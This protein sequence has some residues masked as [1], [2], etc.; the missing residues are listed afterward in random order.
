M[1]NVRKTYAT[2]SRARFGYDEVDPKSTRR[3]RT[4]VAVIKVN[5][6]VWQTAMD[7]ADGDAL[8]VTVVS[9]TE[10]IVRNRR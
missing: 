4:S 3:Q 8:R 7:L 2:H 10:V 9:E 6:A 5:E 1:P